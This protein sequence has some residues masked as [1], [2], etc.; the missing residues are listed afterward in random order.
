MQLFKSPIGWVSLA[1]FLQ[2]LLAANHNAAATAKIAHKDKN[3]C[4]L[5]DLHCSIIGKFPNFAFIV[6]LPYN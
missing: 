4:R 1:F 6:A 3:K 2:L 5:F